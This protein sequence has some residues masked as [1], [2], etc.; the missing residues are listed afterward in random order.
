MFSI[1]L[2]FKW[3]SPCKFYKAIFY[4]LFALSVDQLIAM[5]HRQSC[6]HCK[7]ADEQP[8]R[9]LPINFLAILLLEHLNNKIY[10]CIRISQTQYCSHKPRNDSDKNDVK[11]SK[12][13]WVWQPQKKLAMGSSRGFNMTKTP[14]FCVHTAIRTAGVLMKFT[15]F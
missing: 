2:I 14:T 8:K 4:W 13:R 12:Q 9:N 6:F 7:M 3:A 15:E 11:T 5:L 10:R 1:H